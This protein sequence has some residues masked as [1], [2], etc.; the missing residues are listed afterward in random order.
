MVRKCLKRDIEMLQKLLVKEKKIVAQEYGLT[1][2]GID[3]W[4][5]R[6]RERRREFQWYLNNLYAIEKRDP[7]MKKILLSAKKEIY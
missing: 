6:I 3:S 2:R 4:L 7:R 5:H 1:L